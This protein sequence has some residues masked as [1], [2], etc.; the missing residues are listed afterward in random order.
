MA[1]YQIF[2]DGGSRGNPGMASCAFV[3]YDSQSKLIFQKGFPL[4]ITTNNV[5]EYTAV[6]KAVEWLASGT[7][8]I[9]KLDS[10]LVV[11]QLNGIYKIKDTKLQDLVNK[12]L[13][14]IENCKLKISFK[15]I[16]R[17]KNIV[18]DLLVNK[19]LD[20]EHENE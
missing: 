9:F 4:G 17:E 10:L 20:G 13:L 16:P 18:A 7:E 3:V 15:H 11:Q 1:N 2:T 5:A 12:I 19:T 6:L 8:A 14:K